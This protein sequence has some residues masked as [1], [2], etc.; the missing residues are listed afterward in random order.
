MTSFGVDYII[1]SFYRDIFTLIEQQTISK[2]IIMSYLMT[3]CYYP[4]HKKKKKKIRATCMCI[5]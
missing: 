5:P 1:Y 2:L 4:V 3:F